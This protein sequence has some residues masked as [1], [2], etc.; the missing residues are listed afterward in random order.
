MKKSKS[1]KETVEY[2]S[3]REYARS[4][5]IHLTT[6]Q[7]AI[8][9]GRLSKSLIKIGKHNKIFPEIAD[10][11]WA[12]NTQ[13]NK[14]NLDTV[15]N[16]NANEYG[17]AKT[18]DQDKKLKEELNKLPKTLT[19]FQKSITFDGEAPDIAESRAHFEAY[20]AKMMEL[21][22]KEKQRE[23]I[24]VEE[25][26]DLWTEL[27]RNFQGKIRAIP[28]KLTPILTA[29]LIED[30]TEKILTEA[31]DETLIELSGLKL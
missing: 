11:E 13:H 24:P 5:N 28:T 15:G 7:E 19:G 8:K 4:R 27:L 17:S 21:E 12:T 6:V 25:I 23:L 29:S 22:Y 20:K 2:I 9:T 26:T 10:Q 31:L 1:K 18:P 3:Q 16:I 14:R 30:E